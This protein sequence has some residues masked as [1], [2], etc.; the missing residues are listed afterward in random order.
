VLFDKGPHA[1]DLVCWWLGGKPTVVSCHDDSFGGGEAMISLVLER[2]GCTVACEFSFLSRYPNTYSLVGDAGRIDAALFE[3][4]SFDLTG[5]DGGR[6]KIKLE[7]PV[8]SMSEFGPVM[9]DNFLAVIRG[10]AQPL[11]PATE[12]LHSVELIDECYAR[13][14]RYEMP[15]H[16]AWQRVAHV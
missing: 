3:F 14:Q 16:D 13:R 11:V 9:I 7:S 2:N 10:A 6:Q 5:K 1:L 12:A 8:K 15:W 4:K